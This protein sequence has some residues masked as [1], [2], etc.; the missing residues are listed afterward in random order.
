MKSTSTVL[1]FAFDDVSCEGVGADELSEF[2]ALGLQDRVLVALPYERSLMYESD[3]VA[4]FED[5]VHVVR[6]HDG[7][8]VELLCQVVDEPVDEDGG[9]WVKAGVRFVAEEVFGVQGYRT[10]DSDALLHSAAELI[11]VFVVRTDDVYLFKTV[12]SS[13]AP[14]GRRPVGEEFHREHHVFY[15]CRKVEE[16]AALEQDSDLLSECLLFLITHCRQFSVSVGDVSAVRFHQADEV[17]QQHG[18]SRAA[19]TYDHVAFSGFILYRYVLQHGLA[20]KAFVQMFNLYHSPV[21]IKHELGDDEVSQKNEDT[22]SHD[23][24]G[25]GSSDSER[26]ALGVISVVGGDRRYHETEK[27]HLESAVEYV[28]S[29]VECLDAGDV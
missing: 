29:V 18:L 22:C 16:R 27:R 7:R 21:L 1:C 26:T 9:I 8:H 24:T 12:L 28:E 10:C 20:F 11:R 17:L 25:A 19:G 23:G 4:D 13:F 5:R 6:V 14:L 2:A 15:Y 3:P